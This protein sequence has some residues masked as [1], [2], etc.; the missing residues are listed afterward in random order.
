MDELLSKMC[1]VERFWM[2][3]IADHA[4]FV[5]KNLT[6]EQ[7]PEAE[8][9]MRYH[10]KFDALDKAAQTGN[11]DLEKIR[12]QVISFVNFSNDLL[13]S[14]LTKS[15]VANDYPSF[16][17]HL[18]KENDYYLR[19]I[20]APSNA[21]DNGKILYEL[22]FWL[23]QTSE[24]SLFIMHWADPYEFNVTKQ[25]EDF[26]QQFLNMLNKARLFIS[27]TSPEPVPEIPSPAGTALGPVPALAAQPFP[28]LTLLVSQSLQLTEGYRDHL[29][30]IRKMIQNVETLGVLTT[31]FVDHQTR[32]AEYFIAVLKYILSN[33]NET[34]IFDAEYAGMPF[35]EEYTNLYL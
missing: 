8:E 20:S 3:D 29:L 11:F 17:D 19:L 32:E 26:A 1:N 9:A 27:M 7:S 23:R 12:P 21:I 4:L 15:M 25:S 34:G 13:F 33:S 22:T 10:E 2:R 5:R 35:P 18:V 6:V 28:A 16:R 14:Q 31:R 30:S 24:H